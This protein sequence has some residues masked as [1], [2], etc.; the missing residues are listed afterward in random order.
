MYLLPSS[1]ENPRADGSAGAPVSLSSFISS[2]LR[3]ALA[4]LTSS[5]SSQC[6]NIL[7]RRAYAF[8]CSYCLPSFPKESDFSTGA[9]ELTSGMNYASPIELLIYIFQSFFPAWFDSLEMLI[10]F[11]ASTVPMPT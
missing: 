7:S 5:I 3:A 8:L 2:E 6:C 1:E 9:Q 10:Y 4:V 11:N